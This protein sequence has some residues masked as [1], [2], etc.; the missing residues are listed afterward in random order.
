MEMTQ[1]VNLESMVI[2]VQQGDQ[3]ALTMPALSSSQNPQVFTLV[4]QGYEGSTEPEL[5]LVADKSAS[6]L[7]GPD[8]DA[9]EF[10][11]SQPRTG[12]LETEDGQILYATYTVNPCQELNAAPS[13]QQRMILYVG[14]DGS[15]FVLPALGDQPSLSAVNADGVESVHQY[16]VDSVFSLLPRENG[17]TKKTKG[18]Q[19]R[20][21]EQVIESEL[22]IED[23]LE[24]LDAMLTPL[25]E[26]ARK[27][28]KEPRKKGK[29]DKDGEEKEE[30]VCDLCGASFARAAQYYGHLHSHS[31]ERKWECTLCPTPVE[32]SSQ[33]QLRRHEKQCHLNL[34]PHE[35]SLCSARF[36]RASQLNYHERRIHAG[37]RPHTCQICLKGFFKRS[38][39]RTHL[40]IHLGINKSIC[41]VCG[42]KFNHVSNLIRHTRMHSGIKPYP[43][44]VCGK[45]FT[46]LNAMHQHKVSHQVEKDVSCSLCNKMFKSHAIMRKHVRHMHGDKEASNISSR[47][48]EGGQTRRF[49]CKVCG[50]SFEFAAL[51][52]EHERKHEKETSFH[53]QCCKQD[54]TS[55]D[56][57]KTHSCQT[58][59]ERLQREAEAEAERLSLNSQLESLFQEQSGLIDDDGSLIIYVTQEGQA[60]PAQVHIKPLPTVP[61]KDVQEAPPPVNSN[62]I[63]DEG[64]LPG[65]MLLFENNTIAV[66]PENNSAILNLQVTPVYMPSS[67]DVSVP[68]S[69]EEKCREVFMSSK[70]DL[71]LSHKTADGEKTA[72]DP[73]ALTTAEQLKTEE[74]AQKELE[75]KG[76][77][78]KKRRVARIYKCTEC[79]KVFMKNSNYKQHLGTHF[80]DQ[81]NYCC[82]MCGQ[83]Y[84]WKSTLNK[85]ILRMHTTTKPPQ[86][87]CEICHREYASAGLVQDHIKRDHYKQRPHSCVVCKKTFYK[88]YDLTIHFRTHTKER[89]YICRTCGKR[90]YHLSHVIRHE[91]IHSGHRPYKCVDCGKLFNQSSSL[92]SHRKR[93]TQSGVEKN[94]LEDLSMVEEVVQAVEFPMDEG[95]VLLYTA[96]L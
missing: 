75:E 72:E 63:T 82:P 22:H 34:R 69:Q 65:D 20:R 8:V 16:A 89:P 91:R 64:A 60:E 66:P 7:L 41:E 1:P 23:K 85:H 14:E 71:L 47:T 74:N 3:A 95:N 53:C 10:S 54:F 84:A 94:V 13:D 87:H 18:G 81:M 38:D 35:C 56:L 30:Y 39:L 6:H 21:T 79:S 44:T 48:K 12:T 26:K 43:C 28:K 78:P 2:L 50:E 59:E 24:V 40:N 19:R 83:F 36:D 9:V 25:P 92:K 73:L 68:A 42:K 58:P 37:E 15:T 32:F 86:C 49:Y 5:S 70:E 4:S 93:H 62:S 11:D 80:I 27:V 76:R 57:L 55:V 46:Q 96:T 88:K 33:S 52:K 29:E 67:A 90:F 61:V 51:L 17:I 77:D 31:G 45:R